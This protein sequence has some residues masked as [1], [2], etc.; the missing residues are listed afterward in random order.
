VASEH[1]LLT[2]TLV[3]MTA[4]LRAEGS[5]DVARHH[6]RRA[7]DNIDSKIEPG[8]RMAFAAPE[9]VWFGFGRMYQ[10]LRDESSVEIGVFRSLC[11]A[12]HWLGLPDE[13]SDHLSDAV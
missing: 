2:L 5:A 12:E 3:D 1:G 13:C 4:A 11:E 7:A 8:A 6:A 9:D 10:A